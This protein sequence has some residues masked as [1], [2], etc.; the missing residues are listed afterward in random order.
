[1][2]LN[3]LLVKCIAGL[4]IFST[5]SNAEELKIDKTETTKTNWVTGGKQVS[6]EFKIMSLNKEVSLQQIQLLV[7]QQKPG[8]LTYP[9]IYDAVQLKNND[10]LMI[11]SKDSQGN[12][13]P[14]LRIRTQDKNLQVDILDFGGDGSAYNW[15][16]DS[17][18][19]GWIRVIG[20]DQNQ[21]MIQGSPFKI[22]NLGKGDLAKV[23]F[24]WAFMALDNRNED[25]IEFK[26]INLN[27]GQSV[28][29]LKLEKNCFILP[30]LS[31]NH[32]R[33]E[34]ENFNKDDKNVGYNYGPE[35]WDKNLEFISTSLP[36]L[37]LKKNH[38]IS[39][40]AAKILSIRFNEAEA[41]KGTSFVS[42]QPKQNFESDNW[43]SDSI[44][45]DQLPFKNSNCAVVNPVGT[46]KAKLEYNEIVTSTA[47]EFCLNEDTVIEPAVKAKVCGKVSRN[48][49]F[50]YKGHSIIEAQFDYH[51]LIATVKKSS[52]PISAIEFSSQGTSYQYF[53]NS[54]GSENDLIHSYLVLSEN[55][56]LFKAR[57]SGPWNFY[58]VDIKDEKFELHKVASFGYPGDE[59]EY[60]K[61]KDFVYFS[62]GQL[63]IQRSP[64]KIWQSA[65]QLFHIIDHYAFTVYQFKNSEL[66]FSALDLSGSELINYSWGK[67]EVWSG[68]VPIKCVKDMS[69]VLEKSKWFSQ[70]LI[71]DAQKKSLD[72]TKKFKEQ[73]AKGCHFKKSKSF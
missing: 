14:V 33:L 2:N 23:D 7:N 34:R 54:E 53:S 69:T 22:I 40:P 72:F 61:E 62:K 6:S 49:A 64:F 26:V 46:E 31:F 39:A 51:P 43:Q 38:V 48:T 44:E 65:N 20:A 1:M 66:V 27:S 35:W 36:Q 24:P 16:P 10:I 58:F 47:K 25:K 11:V 5:L 3:G 37:K 70:N 68:Q 30:T 41:K 57:G 9:S 19:K 15:F 29:S 56:L 8:L 52:Y 4:V 42:D 17:R 13:Y 12:N 50:S 60:V 71:W 63:L 18:L 73:N 67:A 55:Q 32:P 45:I 21:Y 28:T 59:A